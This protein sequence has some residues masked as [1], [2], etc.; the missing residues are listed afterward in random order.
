MQHW[1][2]GIPHG[3]TPEEWALAG[4]PIKGT[5]PVCGTAGVRFSGFTENLRESGACSQCGAANRQRQMAFALRKKLRLATRR[6]LALPAG[7]R[8]Y[9]AEIS[10]A[11]HAA[12][13]P[14]PGYVCSGYWGDE[15][16]PGSTV[17]GSRHE[18]LEHLSFAD[19]TL[20]FILTSDVL[21]HVSD[22]YRAHGE[23]FRALRPGGWHI[24]TVP[25][26]PQMPND[27][28][29]ALRRDGEIE[30]LAEA[31]YHGDPLRPTQ[32]ILVW[33]IFG[34]EM[35]S[36]LEQ[37]GFS[38]ATMQVRTPD[39]GILGDNA[40]VFTARKPPAGRGRRGRWLS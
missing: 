9:N 2:L 5:C 18:D 23:I 14:S 40:F 6:P 4:N 39:Q 16:A 8:L 30:Y 32:G 36:R 13:A 19:G 35:L 17:N 7:C 22:A 31:L 20:D 27:D 37:T 11:L 3:V 26:I 38:T 28:V 12:L 25:F 24:F 29:R 33:R 34:R 10:G 1:R 21:E 15:V